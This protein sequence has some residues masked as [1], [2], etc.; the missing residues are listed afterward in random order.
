MNL[1]DVTLIPVADSNDVYEYVW[2]NVPAG[3][4][5]ITAKAYDNE[6]VNTVSEPVV[7]NVRN[8]GD[9]NG[10][11]NINSID[12]KIMTENWLVD[13]SYN[14]EVGQLIG[15]WDF[16]QGSGTDAN[17]GSG[18]NNTATLHGDPNWV[19]GE[20]DLDG[21]GD[22]LQTGNSNTKLKLEDAYTIAVK[23]NAASCTNGL[24][25]SYNKMRC[26]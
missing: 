3:T 26:S 22:Y 21:A 10:D 1:K 8:S 25:R 19:E 5:T 9:I 17:D 16:N 2:S 15:K 20:I 12:L 6:D 23:L 4:Y 11:G 18:N 14:R 7:I 24:G 13:N